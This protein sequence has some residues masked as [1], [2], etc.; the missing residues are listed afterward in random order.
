LFAR[1][2]RGAAFAIGSALV[3]GAFIAAFA[4]AAA[5]A[6]AGF[7]GFFADLRTGFL[8]QS[9][10]VKRA[11]H[12]SSGKKVQGAHDHC[13]GRAHVLEGSHEQNGRIPE[14]APKTQRH[15]AFHPTG[16]GTAQLVHRPNPERCHYRTDAK[17]IVQVR[18][19]E[20]A[21]DIPCR[22]KTGIGA[23]YE[24]ALGAD[25]DR[26]FFVCSTVL[27]RLSLRPALRAES[28]LNCLVGSVLQIAGCTTAPANRY[29]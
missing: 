17:Q 15:H 5:T 7:L 11:L 3:A 20:C 25:Q 24:H 23:V 2:G 29:H 4:T 19:L 14:E 22:G 12:A 27:F 10:E 6:L 13:T 21:Q 26:D 28:I 8:D 16:Q 18:H 1:L 9:C